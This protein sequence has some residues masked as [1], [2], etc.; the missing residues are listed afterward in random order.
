MITRH[1]ASYLLAGLLFVVG[2]GMS[3]WSNGTLGGLLIILSVVV[4]FVGAVAHLR[5]ISGESGDE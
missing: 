3:L 5:A 4:L 1:T 2:F